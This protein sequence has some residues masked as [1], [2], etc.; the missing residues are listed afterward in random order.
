[1]Y[2]KNKV[3]FMIV[4]NYFA[5][6]ALKRNAISVESVNFHFKTKLSRAFVALYL[7]QGN[8]SADYTVDFHIND[9]IIQMVLTAL[10]LTTTGNS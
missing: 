4:K 10:S 8:I 1:M 5:H 3:V 7:H 6:N 2:F 9:I